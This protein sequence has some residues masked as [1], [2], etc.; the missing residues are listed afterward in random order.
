M[1][2]LIKLLDNATNSKI[3]TVHSNVLEQMKIQASSYTVD[4]MAGE[5]TGTLIEYLEG[6]NIITEITGEEDKWKIGVENLLG[7]NQLIPYDIIGG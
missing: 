5:Y 2:R 4:T 1:L 6:K 7:T 3:R